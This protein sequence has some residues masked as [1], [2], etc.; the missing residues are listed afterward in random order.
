MQKDAMK[1]L[2]VERMLVPPLLLLRPLPQLP[3]LLPLLSR[4]HH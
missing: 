4:R 1:V 2:Q 3:E